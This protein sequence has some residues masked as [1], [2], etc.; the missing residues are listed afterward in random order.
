MA[1]PD[2]NTVNG[3]ET[4]PDGRFRIPIATLLVV[5]FGALTLVAVATV[6]YV[7]IY[8]GGRNTVALLTDKA[9]L[10]QEA[11]ESS[12]RHQLGPPQR[13]S[14]YLVRLFDQGI[15]DIG[16]RAQIIDTLRGALAATPQVTGLGFVWPD[17][18]AL[19][20]GRVGGEIRVLEDSTAITENLHDALRT[21]QRDRKP[22]WGEPVWSQELRAT[23]LTYRAP[24]LIDGRFR[25]ALIIAISLADLSRFLSTLSEGDE[26]EAVILSD[27]EYVIAHKN[28][29]RDRFEF[30]DTGRQPP[31][32][33]IDEI[34]DP[35]IAQMWADG[36]LD[37]AIE[38]GTGF[39]D[40]G[41]IGEV[42]RIGNR[43]EYFQISE[44]RGFGPSVW[45]TVIY[46]PAREVGEGILRLIGS[47]VLGLVVLVLAVFGSLMIGRMLARRIG[48]VAAAPMRWRLASVSSRSCS[49]ISA[50]FLGWP[51]AW[52]PSRSPRC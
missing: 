34:E 25:G 5:G 52:T 9:E 20:V 30:S 39:G 24:I 11:V 23:L 49:R 29:A 17:R 28:L 36:D 40:I 8:S 46:S 38:K 50:V 42:V 6:L 27:R 10:I 14:R 13:Q 48:V 31:L 32:P 47:A 4:P 16:N 7:G 1:E 3:T 41:I 21:L 12:L 51:N 2:D 15:V 26:I 19:R 43:G 35:V 45:M 22:Y 44:I 18:T 33:R 37:A